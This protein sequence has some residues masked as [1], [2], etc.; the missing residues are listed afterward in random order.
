MTII[1]QAQMENLLDPYKAGK[2]TA[3]SDPLILQQVQEYRRSLGARMIPLEHSGIKKRIPGGELHVSRKI[4]GE[5]NVLVIR[6]D[7]IVMVNPGG[8]IRIGLPLMEE[9]LVLLKK[10]N[11]KQAMVAGELY[12]DKPAGRP[13]V[14]D[15][16]R[17]ARKPETQADLNLLKFA[18]F[19]LIEISQESPGT[20]NETLEQINSIFKGDLIHAVESVKVTDLGEIEKI[21]EK[22]VQQENAEGAVVRSDEAGIFKIKP[23]HTIDVVV[24]GFTEGVEDRRGLL[25]DL[26]VAVIR[27][28]G[29]LH[30]LG[31]V[32]GGFSDDQRS[33]FL[34]DLKDIAAQSEY[35]EIS[36]DRVAYQMVRPEWVI[37]ISCLDLITSSTRGGR[38]E[39]MVLNWNLQDACYEIVRSM[40]LASIISPQ[41]I[42]RRQDKS[43]CY[44]DI[45]INQI[46]DLV[47][48]AHVEK[49]SL[50]VTLPTATIL[51]RKVC[52]KVLKGAAMVRKLV[53]WKTNKEND[54][55]HFPAFVLHLTDFSPNRKSPLNRDIRVSDSLEQME[56]FWD[57]LEKKNF[58]KGWQEV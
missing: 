57:A 46:S 20:F 6:E 53:L 10:A 41:F 23:R 3:L 25:H 42:R 50:Q 52:T 48:V 4:D 19:D 43:I 56:V 31:R 15:V 21:F 17:V 58:I 16:V 2:A 28:E 55:E 35:H 33:A 49:N 5:F 26:L 9:T 32:G 24:V 39:R 47:E 11:I 51:K 38:I 30:L 36:T 37:E 18:V 54:S 27:K 7:Q 22:W 34:S 29:T 12:F 1:D 44:E 14:H 8:T 40:P 45:R 13:R